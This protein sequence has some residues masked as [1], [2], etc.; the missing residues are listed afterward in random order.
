MDQWSKPE[1]KCM[2]LCIMLKVVKSKCLCNWQEHL[3]SLRA[4]M[5]MK[6][7][8]EFETVL[9]GEKQVVIIE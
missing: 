6:C 2:P 3:H 9:K 8:N 4:H 5:Q 1:M 7:S